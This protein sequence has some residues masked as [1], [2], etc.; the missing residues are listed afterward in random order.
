[1]SD[2]DIDTTLFGADGFVKETLDFILH[3]N[4]S[5]YPNLKKIRNWSVAT[6][7]GFKNM[8]YFNEI[9]GHIISQYRMSSGE[10]TLIYL[11]DV[12]NNLVVK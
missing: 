7:K 9:N 2:P 1:M 10:S 5:Y 11:I 8:P 12:I 6:D 4:K 3:N